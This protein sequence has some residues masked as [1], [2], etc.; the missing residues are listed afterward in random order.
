MPIRTSSGSGTP[1]ASSGRSTTST[2][3]SKTRRPHRGSPGSPSPRA[4]RAARPEERLKEESPMAERDIK[5]LVKDRY[6]KAALAVTAGSGSCCA[7]SAC[8]GDEPGQAADPITS[9]LY[10][11]AEAAALPA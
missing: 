3:I 1:T 9:N 5:Q 10:T 8:C 2:T 4:L 6:G 11:E 7:A